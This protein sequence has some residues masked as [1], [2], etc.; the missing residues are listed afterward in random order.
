MTPDAARPGS[1]EDDSREARTLGADARAVEGAERMRLPETV[2]GYV[3]K[4]SRQGQIWL[5]VGSTASFL[6]SLV[7]LEMQRRVVNEALDQR[8][9]RTLAYLCAIYIASALVAGLIKRWINI[10]RGVVSERATLALRK[11]VHAVT[12]PMEPKGGEPAKE[13][14]GT[15]VS[16]AVAEV[17][18][19][20]G[21]VGMAI[22]EPLLQ[23]G[24]LVFTFAYLVVLQPWMGLLSIVLFSPQIFFVPRMQAAIN[25]RAAVRIKTVR[26]VGAQLIEEMEIDASDDK[27]HFDRKITTVLEL[28]VQIY[29]LKYT[30]NFY[31]N[32]LHHLGVVGVLLVGGWFVIEGRT[33]A[34]TIVAF[35]SGLSQ[36]KEPWTDLINYYREATTAQVK[37]G[38]V[39]SALDG[40]R[41]GE[42]PV[43]AAT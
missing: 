8:H 23:S 1:G 22:S 17:E 21:F 35:L 9:L 10:Y 24:I 14:E 30:M 13:K 38:L 3:W 26:K 40:P 11:K 18:P 25:R 41:D 16:V 36:L 5:C 6:L 29:R 2:F 12:K 32:S 42:T 31:M 15:T 28:N 7:P 33:E 37:Y 34:G 19:V 20:G 43:T 27:R 39:K 4:V